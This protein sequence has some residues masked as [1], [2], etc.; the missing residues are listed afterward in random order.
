MFSVRAQFERIDEVGD[1]QR[2]GTEDITVASVGL[3]V[4]F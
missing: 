3:L 4:R 2:T 1:P